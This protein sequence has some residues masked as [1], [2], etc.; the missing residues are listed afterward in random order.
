[1]PTYE[2]RCPE[3]GNEQEVDLRFRVV[4]IFQ[5]C[6]NCGKPTE[7]RIS[8]P[9]PASIPTTARG[10][11]LETLNHEKGKGVQAAP[12]DRPRIEAA[13]AKGLDQKRETV[14]RGF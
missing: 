13:L 12:K 7:R 3:C 1:M 8:L 10:H 14:G 6:S 9:Y 5:L 11:I 2:Y 4:A